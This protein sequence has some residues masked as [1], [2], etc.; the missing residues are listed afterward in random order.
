MVI[1][2]ARRRA[3]GAGFQ[4]LTHPIW[5]TGEVDSS[6]IGKLDQFLGRAYVRFCEGSLPAFPIGRFWRRIANMKN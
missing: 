4:L 2:R 1:P 5:W 6:V 3:R